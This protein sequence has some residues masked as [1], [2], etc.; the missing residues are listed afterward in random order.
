MNQKCNSSIFV[1][2]NNTETIKNIFCCLFLE[3]NK[4][5]IQAI[6]NTGEKHR[7]SFVSHYIS[8][9]FVSHQSI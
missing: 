7:D 4:T 6:L 5:W 1:Q 9:V 8:I 2:E 3:K